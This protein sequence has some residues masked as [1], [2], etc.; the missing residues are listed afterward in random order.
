VK[1]VKVTH[2]AAQSER[3]ASL[4]AFRGFTVA[5]MILV[6]NPGSWS[7][8][9]PQLL[10]ARWNGWTATDWVFPF[11]IFIG[12][13]SMTY[14]MANRVERG[15]SR[16]DLFLQVLKRAA[17][18]FAIGFLLNFFPKM[19]IETV[20]IPGVL[21][22][23]AICYAISAA[24]MLTFKPRGQAIWLVSCL[25]VYMAAMYLIPVPGL[26]A[27]FME[28]GKNLAAYIDSVLLT[29]HMWV[30]SKTWDPEGALS[31]IPAVAT[32]LFGS[33]TG[34]LLRSGESRESKTAWLLFA[35]FA[36]LL[37][38]GVWDW[39]MPINKSLWTSSYAVFMAGWALLFLGSFYW[40]MDVKGWQKWA[41]FF[42]IYG[43]N[44]LAAYVLS[45]VVMKVLLFFTYPQA[46]RTTLTLKTVIYNAAF[47]PFF[48]NPLNSSL[49]FAL[50]YNALMFLVAYVLWKRKIFI[51][52]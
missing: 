10:H 52:I 29:G 17:I 15:D 21:Q 46:D 18:I 24:I 13:V 9:Y 16:R 36:C 3:L 32:A 12:G 11:F 2:M 35:G 39:F 45:I 25:V 34:Y 19:N 1:F 26:G 22:R 37:V 4:D 20:R 41:R 5:G 40:L 42:V 43:S 23:I 6:N 27:G 51:K 28:P 31:T 44:A 47:V 33:L 48:A 49:A 50:V 7:E 30:Q 8:A 14:S 38:G